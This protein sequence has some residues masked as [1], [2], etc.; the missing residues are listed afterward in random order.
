MLGLATISLLYCFGSTASSLLPFLDIPSS[1]KILEFESSK[2]FLLA[3]MSGSLADMPCFSRKTFRSL[4]TNLWMPSIIYGGLA[5]LYH[6]LRVGIANPA[7]KLLEF[8]AVTV[9]S[10]SVGLT[11][12]C[13]WV[14]NTIGYLYSIC[15]TIKVPY[16]LLKRIDYIKKIV[17]SPRFNKWLIPSFIF[18]LAAIILDLNYLFPA[19]QRSFSLVALFDVYFLL[20]LGLIRYRNIYMNRR[21]MPESLAFVYFPYAV[22]AIGCCYYLIL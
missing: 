20:I 1:Y 17:K 19:I 21:F 14:R 15:E 5:Y 12:Y 2:L 13:I 6:F 22:V 3:I 4:I 7:L 10:L 11:V 16:G 8:N 9:V 18:I